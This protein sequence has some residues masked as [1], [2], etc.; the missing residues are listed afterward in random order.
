MASSATDEKHHD[1]PQPVTA[2]SPTSPTKKKGFFAAKKKDAAADNEK[3]HR[4]SDSTD[5]HADATA[6]ADLPVEPPVVPVG[7]TELFRY[8]TKFELFL[9]AIGLVCAAASGAAQVGPFSPDP[10]LFF[11]I[12]GLGTEDFP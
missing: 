6:P 2:S 1:L 12:G 11:I 7:F 5:A 4:D 8:S 3:Q 9:D 10:D